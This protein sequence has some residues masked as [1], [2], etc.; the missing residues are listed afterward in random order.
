MAR[1]C[2]GHCFIGA[3]AHCDLI[4]VC[5]PFSANLF[6]H[7]YCEIVK[8]KTSGDPF[9][10]RAIPQ[11]TSRDDYT[12]SSLFLE[13]AYL[14]ARGASPFVDN[15]RQRKTIKRVDGEWGGVSNATFFF[16]SDESHLTQIDLV[17]P[18]NCSNTEMVEVEQEL[19]PVAN[20]GYSPDLF[21]AL[22]HTDRNNKLTN[23]ALVPNCAYSSSRASG[24]F[25]AENV[26]TASVHEYAW[27]LSPSFDGQ[28]FLTKDEARFTEFNVTRNTRLLARDRD[29]WRVGRSAQSDIDGLQIGS[30]EISFGAVVLATGP[31]SSPGVRTISSESGFLWER[32]NTYGVVAEVLG[33]CPPR[34]SGIAAADS[35]CMVVMRMNCQAFDEDIEPYPERDAFVGNPVCSLETV[36]M[37]WGKGFEA[38]AD[39]VAI[40]AGLYGRVQPNF[41][42]GS[43]EDQFLINAFF[44]ALFVA[45]TVDIRPSLVQQV[46]P[47]ING[48][49]IVFTLLPFYLSL[50]LILFSLATRHSRLPIPQSVWDLLVIGREEAKVPTRESK[51]DLFPESNTNLALALV[52]DES[53]EGEVLGMVSDPTFANN[54]LPLKERLFPKKS[55]DSS[56][57]IQPDSAILE[58][59]AEKEKDVGSQTSQEETSSSTRDE[60]DPWAT[61]AARPSLADPSGIYTRGRISYL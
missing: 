50:V 5:L 20:P 11:L 19:Q 37:V 29:D 24:I 40:V 46:A 1:I 22:V 30:V 16:Q 4:I 28:V 55:S 33:D 12:T 25:D 42:D 45:G 57:P 44:A 34:P 9:S 38:D 21:E 32:R 8:Q 27:L 49:Y 15:R 53:G 59:K 36:Y 60:E 2:C 31:E 13:A 56:L 61:T 39:L 26:G 17:L 35:S 10:L 41:F 14:I 43:A 51:K 47:V 23:T 18:L 3:L 6:A 58:A 7:S 52:R 54:G 48:L